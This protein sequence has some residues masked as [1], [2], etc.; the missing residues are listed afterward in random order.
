MEGKGRIPT[1]MTTMPFYQTCHI[2]DGAGIN[3]HTMQEL[4]CGMCPLGLRQDEELGWKTGGR[5]ACQT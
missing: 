4:G 5:A 2:M 1:T 3:T